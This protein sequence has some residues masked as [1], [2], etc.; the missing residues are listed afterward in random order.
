ML[1]ARLGPFCQLP[2]M[3]VMGAFIVA[4]QII[5][6]LMNVLIGFSRAFLF[7]HALLHAA[8]SA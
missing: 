6:V 2:K 1:Y 4:Q 3:L 8:G 7:S 5:L